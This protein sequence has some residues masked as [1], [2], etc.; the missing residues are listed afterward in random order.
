MEGV[1]GDDDA[2]GGQQAQR[3]DLLKVRYVPALVGVDE[4]DVEL[5]AGESV[6]A[7]WAVC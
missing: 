4:D 7:G 3:E 5:L 1:V 6:D 2:R